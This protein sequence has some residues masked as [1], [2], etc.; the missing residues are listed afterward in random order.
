[1]TKL[2]EV[3]LPKNHLLCSQNS[4][5]KITAK[6]QEEICLLGQYGVYREA[7]ELADALLNISISDQQIRRVCTHYGTFIDEVLA[8]NVEVMLPRLEDTGEE[9]P[10]YLM[11]DGSMLF[12]RDDGWKELKLA[13]VFNGSKVIDIQENRNET[14]ETIYCSHLGGVKEFF[15]KLERFIV[16]Y[17]H[18]V[19]VGDGAPWIWKWCED[20][21]PGCVQ[22]LDFYHAK[23]KLVL[24]SNAHFRDA[25]KRLNWLNLQLSLLKEDQVIKVLANVKNMICK[26]AEAMKSKAKLIKYYTDHED[27]MYYKT[28]IE[29]GYLIGSGPIEAA[30]R[31]VIQQRLK[32]SGQ[33]WSIPGANAIANL[34][35]YRKLET[36]NYSQSIYQKLCTV[37]VG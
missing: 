27:R 15:P 30:H 5:F 32:L 25:D 2:C 26:N 3:E 1:M 11:M 21:Y 14:V 34:R 10:T 12:T 29:K 33:K 37:T 16:G 28:F 4:P 23:E 9:D 17:K 18:L 36:N 22:I 31:S 8:S 20:N 35:C 13:R 24:L 19:V 7:S 6:L